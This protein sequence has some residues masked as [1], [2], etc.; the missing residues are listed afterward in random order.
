MIKIFTSLFA[1]VLLT[2]AYSQKRINLNVFGD[3]NYE[4]NYFPSIPSGSNSANELGSFFLGEQDFF[5][6]GEL[7]ER[8][9]YLGEVIVK[10]SASSSSGFDISAERIRIK[11]NYYKDHSILV[12]K[13]HTALN[14]WNDVY[15]HGRIFFPTIDRPLNFSYFLPIHSLGIRAQGQNIGK[16]KFGYDVMVSNGM[17]ST[18]FSS[19]GLNYA[20]AASVHIKPKRGSRV[21]V[22]YYN[23]MLPTNSH[24]P[25]AHSGTYHN[26]M[27]NDAVRLNE[28][29]FS[30]ARFRKAFEVLNE[31]S[32][33]LSQTDSL[34]NSINWTNYIYLGYRIKDKY[35]PYVLA[36]VMRISG[37]E[38]HTLRI[39]TAKF[40][41][42]FKWDIN[43]FV[44]FKIQFEHY[45]GI[46]GIDDPNVID[47]LQK[48][49]VK[50]QLSYAL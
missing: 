4:Y 24:G 49:E 22:G 16:L 17:E 35:V 40:G 7:S 6:T 8:I 19:N 43:P 28:F 44:N 5:V 42:G 31:A 23:D 48:F 39:N 34:G 11:F 45:S 46:P 10:G 14:Y 25:H 27:Y 2:T 29:Y 9:S 13:M 38:L 50:T 18:D 30:Y 37:N 32:V 3:I 33:T 36:D 21:M 12:G 1:F 20:Y 26:H 41:A 47:N 15:H